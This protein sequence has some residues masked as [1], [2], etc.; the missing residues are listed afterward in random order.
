[1]SNAA[2]KIDEERLLAYAQAAKL[3]LGR[4]HL[5]DFIR[6]TFPRYQVDPFHERLCAELELFFD[7]VLKKEE[8]RLII[9]APPQSGKS[10][11]ASRRFPAWALGRNPGMNIITTSY[12]SDRAEMNSK[13]VQNI[14]E[15][16]YYADLFPDIRLNL[17]RADI[18]DIKGYEQYKYRAAGI[19]GGIT[20]L[21][22]HILII[23]DPVK[24]WEEANSATI[25][26]K[27]WGSY[28]AAAKT[29]LAEGGGIILI[30]T[31][32]NE[33]DLAGKVLHSDEGGRWRL[34]HYPALA[35]MDADEQR[36]DVGDHRAEGEPL[37]PSLYSRESMERIRDDYYTTGQGIIWQTLYQGR[38]QPTIGMVY[39]H[40]IGDDPED[41]TLRRYEGRVI[42]PKR[43]YLDV[44]SENQDWDFKEDDAG[45][46]RIWEKPLHG[47]NYCA[48]LD[49]SEGI[50][51]GGSDTDSHVLS[52]MRRGI[53][54]EI[55]RSIPKPD[56]K[57][58]EI[59][60][61]CTVACYVSKDD[62]DRMGLEVIQGLLYYNHAPIF[63][64]RNN[65][66]T[67][68]V[69]IIFEN[70]YPRHLI[71][72]ERPPAKIRSRK[73]KKLGFR[74][75]T[76]NKPAIMAGLKAAMREDQYD[77][78]DKEF[79]F[80]CRHFVNLNGKLGAEP[81]FH[82]DRVMSRALMLLAHQKA[83]WL[84]PGNM[85][86]VRRKRKSYKP[87]FEETGY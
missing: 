53:Q 52:I 54:D 38:P 61:P 21:G 58:G 71:L 4:R 34:L 2:Q 55:L 69:D 83:P 42:E 7:R 86:T 17:H 36:L 25:Q 62:L 84:R 40:T 77:D 6:Y 37:A 63:A 74:T 56:I 68:V 78:F 11:I 46:W 23:D 79:F 28:N 33:Q 59:H 87:I 57:I 35:E 8:P 64:E 26:E 75:G 30:M 9:V 73:S 12:S 60:K 44:I 18:W 22:A 70:L 72:R 19:L 14:I 81:R 13:D 31:R 82:D 47:F 15:G 41:K 48:G 43:C 32:W 80:E 85:P 39:F 16:D 50:E 67:G 5:I 24:D 65:S 10:E 51:G 20:G 49:T 76:A 66:G 3:E 45:F 27:I 1:M 29:R